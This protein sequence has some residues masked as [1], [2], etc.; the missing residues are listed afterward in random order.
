MPGRV[1]D[2][3]VPVGCVEKPG[4]N[5]NGDTA[6]PL[7][8]GLIHDICEVKSSFVILVRLLLVLP[9]ILLADVSQIVKQMTSQ[10]GLA[11]INVPNDYQVQ[12]VLNDGLLSFLVLEVVNFGVILVEGGHVHHVFFAFLSQGLQFLIK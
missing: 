10:G 4:G 8:V 3:K 5:L 1:Q 9:Q 12:V 6:L 11:G 7:L 2:G